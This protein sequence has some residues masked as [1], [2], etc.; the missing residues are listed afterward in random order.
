MQA[1]HDVITSLHKQSQEQAD[2]QQQQQQ[3]PQPDPSTCEVI[4]ARCPDSARADQTFS[5]RDADRRQEKHSVDAL[6]DW[7]RGK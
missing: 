1:S 6:V 5:R 2:I 4:P 7:I 3:Q